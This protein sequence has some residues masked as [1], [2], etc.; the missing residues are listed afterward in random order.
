MAGQMTADRLRSEAMGTL[1]G[2]LPGYTD[3]DPVTDTQYKIKDMSREDDDKMTVEVVEHASGV[4]G[5][6]VR[7]VIDV[8]VEQIEL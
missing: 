6:P 2:W 5:D 1:L 7:F 8:T 4:E 3:G